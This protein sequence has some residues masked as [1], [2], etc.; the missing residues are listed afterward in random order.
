[1]TPAARA[2]ESSTNPATIHPQKGRLMIQL[3][4]VTARAE[5]RAGRSVLLP[6]RDAG[7]PVG[8]HFDHACAYQI[9][10]HPADPLARGAYRVGNALAAQRAG[11]QALTTAGFSLVKQ[12]LDHTTAHIIERQH[13]DALVGPAQAIGKGMHQRVSQRR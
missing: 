11:N 1:M 4:P 13:R 6:F 5:A 2:D 8:Q 7:A 10:H 12:V 3:Q 9:Q